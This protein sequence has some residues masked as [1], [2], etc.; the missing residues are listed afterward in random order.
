MIFDGA[1]ASQLRVPDLSLCKKE[2]DF[3]QIKKLTS[4]RCDCLG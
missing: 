4:N 1:G 2:A 3:S